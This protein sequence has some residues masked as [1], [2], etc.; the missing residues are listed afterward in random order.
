MKDLLQLLQSLHKSGWAK[1]TA[2]ADRVKR[3]VVCR[4]S[5]PYAGVR[6]T[7]SGCY[8]R[9]GST[10]DGYSYVRVGRKRVGA[11]R[12]VWKNLRGAIPPGMMVLHRCDNRRCIR[13]DHLFL[14]AAADNSADM[15]R[16]GRSAMCNATGEKNHNARLTD[17][18]VNEIRNRW[19]NADKRW[20]LQTALAVELSVSQAT[21]SMI[22]RS[23]SR[24]EGEPP[25]RGQPDKPTFECRE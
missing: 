12:L 21:I 9:E 19:Q 8:E 5:T 16:K 11:H 17:E 7:E 20:G 6:I 10:I 25:Y 4:N 13:L 15:V 1:V 24:V 3:K 18:Q 23:K 14:G 2:L 22:V